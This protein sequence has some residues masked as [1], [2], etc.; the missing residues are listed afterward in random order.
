MLAVSE[1]TARKVLSELLE[2]FQSL[3][4][5]AKSHIG[6]HIAQK[7]GNPEI[8]LLAKLWVTSI[9]LLLLLKRLLDCF[10]TQTSCEVLQMSE[11]LNYRIAT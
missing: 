3:F 4:W 6:K 10:L 2:A 7:N 5:L 1:E 8:R 11:H 9:S